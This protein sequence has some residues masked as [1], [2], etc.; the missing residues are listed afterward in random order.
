MSDQQPVFPLYPKTNNQALASMITGVVG[1]AGLMVACVLPFCIPVLPLWFIGFGIAAVVTGVMGRKAVSR[2]QGIEAGEGMATVGMI[3]G[4]VCIALA[5]LFVILT[6]LS[7][8][9]LIVFSRIVTEA[10]PVL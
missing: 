4:I 9:G 7:V 5:V 1:V 6:I 8:V 3:L 10:T 2:G